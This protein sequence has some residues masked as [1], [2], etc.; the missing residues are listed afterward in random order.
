MDRRWAPRLTVAAAAVIAIGLLLAI[1]GR[2][3]LL[4]RVMLACWAAGSIL[5]VAAGLL[6]TEGPLR[7]F[8]A[9]VTLFGGGVALAGIAGLLVAAGVVE[10][11]GPCPPDVREDGNEAM[12]APAP[13]QGLVLLGFGALAA[14]LGVIVLMWQGVWWGIRRRVRASSPR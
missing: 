9:G 10:A 3:V 5:L 13:G 1:V 12:C 7:E 6:P 2:S 4:S 14:L 8:R 11:E